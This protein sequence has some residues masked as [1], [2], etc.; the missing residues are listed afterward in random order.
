MSLCARLFC[1]VYAC[2]RS[3]AITADLCWLFDIVSHFFL[4]GSLLLLSIPF[5]RQRSGK[6]CTHQF[7]YASILYSVFCDPFG[8]IKYETKFVSKHFSGQTHQNKHFFRSH[9]A[10]V[11]RASFFTFMLHRV[12]YACMCVCGRV[13]FVRVYVWV[14]ILFQCPLLASPSSPLLFAIRPQKWQYS[15]FECPFEIER[16]PN[17]VGVASLLNYQ[18]VCIDGAMCLT[19]WK[20][21]AFTRSR[22]SRPSSVRLRLTTQM[23]NRISFSCVFPRNGCQ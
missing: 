21:N 2:A 15:M 9:D 22:V 1:A 11:W 3:I 5:H 8:E 17:V 16:A 18:L 4:H 13:A 6:F 14:W 12:L 19:S 10:I 23:W 20:F 7:R